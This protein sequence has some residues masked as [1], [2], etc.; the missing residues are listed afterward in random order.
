VHATATWP[1]IT[2]LKHPARVLIPIKDRTAFLVLSNVAPFK[3]YRFAR[4]LEMSEAAAKLAVKNEGNK[5]EA[6]PPVARR[7]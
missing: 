2:Q 3:F 6:D 1:N 7:E 5:P 4:R